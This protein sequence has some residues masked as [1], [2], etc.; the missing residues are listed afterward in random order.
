MDLIL[1][2]PPGA[3]KGTQ[4]ALLTERLGLWRI[5]TGDLL[6]E[7][8]RQGTPLGARAQSFME[9]G[10]LVPDEV[11]LGLVR[12][13]VAS[14]RA[15]A[16]VI[17]DGFPRNLAQARELDMLLA[18][19]QRPLDAVLLLD[20]PDEVLVQRISGRWSCPQCG[21]VYNTFFEPPR[22]AGVCD[23]CGA[24][25]VHRAD[26]EE[27]TVRRRLEVYRQETEPVVAHYQES[28]VPVQ[29]VNGE[30]SV[31]AVQAELVALLTP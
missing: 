4:G 16:G 30:Q 12:E 2:G 25:L 31:D 19:L 23:A 9:A 17:F 3:G 24:Q 1:F 7:A 18:E 21:A 11:I 8:V 28:G 22:T 5:S 26:D 15:Q 13:A 6:R 29:R 27:A 10:D 20:V 14:E